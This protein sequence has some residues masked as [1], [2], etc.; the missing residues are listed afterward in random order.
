MRSAAW[1]DGRPDCVD[2]KGQAFKGRNCAS[3]TSVTFRYMEAD[4]YNLYPAVGELNQL[5]SNFSMAEIAGEERR[6]GRCDFTHVHVHGRGV[7]GSRH[8]LSQEQETVRSLGQRRPRRFVG[9][10]ASAAD[11]PSSGQLEQRRRWSLSGC[12]QVVGT[13]LQDI[14]DGPTRSTMVGPGCILESQEGELK[15]WAAQTR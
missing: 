11:R 1:R 3:K 12:W 8:H 10:R 4:M 13:W 15:R 5:R 7:P 2:A 14:V 6:F 9:V